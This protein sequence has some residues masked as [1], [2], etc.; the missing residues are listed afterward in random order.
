MLDAAKSLRQHDRP[1]AATT[2]AAARGADAPDEAVA[3][4]QEPFGALPDDEAERLVALPDMD[5]QSTRGSLGA[6]ADQPRSRRRA[7]AATAATTAR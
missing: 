6:R 2:P 3:A 7:P 5:L 4:P 1:A